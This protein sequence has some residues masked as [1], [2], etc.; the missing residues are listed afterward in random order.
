MRKN[1]AV[2]FTTSGIIIILS[3]FINIISNV[4]YQLEIEHDTHVISAFDG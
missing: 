4:D 3:M 1:F 2:I